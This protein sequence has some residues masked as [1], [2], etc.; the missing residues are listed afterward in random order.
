MGSLLNNLSSFWMISLLLFLDLNHHFKMRLQ[1]FA[2]SLIFS[3]NQIC[4]KF[5]EMFLLIYAMPTIAD[6]A[7]AART[8]ALLIR[9]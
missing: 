7:V 2:I 6:E 5:T 4:S 1:E 9:I 3:K 8:I